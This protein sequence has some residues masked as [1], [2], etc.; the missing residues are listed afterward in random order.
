MRAYI[1]AIQERRAEDAWRL[2]EGPEALG[3]GYG[4]RGEPITEAD[5]QRQVASMPTASGRRIRVLPSRTSGT[6]T[7]VDVEVMSGSE[8]PFF[9]HNWPLARKASFRLR[10]VDGQ[11]RITAA[12]SVWEVS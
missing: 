10:E 7:I 11:W 5:F 4:P 12:P 2:L 1:E 6:A 8:A 9:L 3:R